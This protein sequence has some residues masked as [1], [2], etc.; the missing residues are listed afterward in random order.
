MFK[1]TKLWTYLENF[2]LLPKIFQSFPNYKIPDFYST[3]QFKTLVSACPGMFLIFK[4][5]KLKEIKL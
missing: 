5:R 2:T 1:K 3:E 4:K